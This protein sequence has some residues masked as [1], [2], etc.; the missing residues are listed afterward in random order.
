MD[1]FSVAVGIVSLLD[2][3]FKVVNYLKHIEESARKIEDDITVL[4]SE[5]NSLI[6][7]TNSIDDL[8]QSNQDTILQESDRVKRLWEQI[9]G[10][11][12]DCQ[13][14]VGDLLEL[15]VQVIGK[16]GPGASSLMDGFKKVLRKDSKDKEFENVR[17]HMTSFLAGLQMLLTALSV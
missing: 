17:N 11:L 6:I 7:V 9:G 4:I 8:W 1:P 2:V 10:L 16:H 12:K 15:L 3:S 13:H 5:L 14:T